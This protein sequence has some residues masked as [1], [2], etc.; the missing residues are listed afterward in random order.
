MELA[1]MKAAD[2]YRE[3]VTDLATKDSRLREAKVMRLGWRATADEV[4]LPRYE[5]AMILIA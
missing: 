5:L 1:M 4:R 3:F 2:R